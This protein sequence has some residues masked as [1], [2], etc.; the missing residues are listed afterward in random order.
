MKHLKVNN[1]ICA[2]QFRGGTIVQPGTYYGGEIE[3]GTF[4]GGEIEPGTFH[5]GEI[6]PGTFHGGEIEPGTFHHYG[7]EVASDLKDKVKDDKGN[8]KEDVSSDETPV[9]TESKI[10]DG[11]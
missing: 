8:G 3:P 5:G 4:H 6:E 11:D 7:D 1:F 9:D 2:G 10:K